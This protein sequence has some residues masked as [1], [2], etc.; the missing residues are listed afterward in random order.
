MHWSR[1]CVA[2]FVVACQEPRFRA[3]FPEERYYQPDWSEL[4]GETPDRITWL[5]EAS[6]TTL[7]VTSETLIF[8][9]SGQD[10]LDA[11]INGA[12]DAQRLSDGRV[13]ILGTNGYLVVLHGDSVVTLARRGE[14]PGELVAP[15]WLRVLADGS[16]VVWD[17]STR[18]L[19]RYSADS[20]FL[21]SVAVR[22]SDTTSRLVFPLTSRADGAVL[23]RARLPFPSQDGVHLLQ[24]DVVQ[25]LPDGDAG[26]ALL[27]NAPI[28]EMHLEHVPTPSGGSRG[29][30]MFTPPFGRQGDVL[31]G[32]LTTCYVWTGASAVACKKETLSEWWLY[33]D[34]SSGRPV[35]ADNMRALLDSFYLVNVSAGR[36]VAQEEAVL[37]M[38]RADSMPRWG[39]GYLDLDDVLWLPRYSTIPDRQQRVL[40]IDCTGVRALIHIHRGDRIRWARARHLL[41]E[42]R[43]SDGV[44]RLFLLELEEAIPGS[45]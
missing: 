31:A 37:A 17:G 42:R 35:S 30:A 12:R 26:A 43:D 41:V 4:L 36:R 2:L 21:V 40:V 33:Q 3:H 5:D 14:G 27:R 25:L 45:C 10:T 29:V 15:E 32:G 16:I 13:A 22:P 6:A 19:S 9:R 24:G 44:R 18:R 1:C 39:R 38:P 34:R 11:Q 23:A 7:R 8:P 20:G 28:S